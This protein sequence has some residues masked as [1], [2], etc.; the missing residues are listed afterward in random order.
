MAAKRHKRRKR[1]RF[2]VF[3]GLFLPHLAGEPCAQK[4]NGRIISVFEPFALFCGNSTAVFRLPPPHEPEHPLIP[5]FSPAPSGGEGV[6]RTD[7]GA[8]QGFKARIVSGNSHPGCG[9]PGWPAKAS[10]PSKPLNPES[11]CAFCAILR[12]GTPV[13]SL[14]FRPSP[15]SRLPCLRP[16]ARCRSPFHKETMKP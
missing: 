14:N 6:R 15:V 16:A 3:G 8:V 5:S 10:C 12:P 7:E 2:A 9:L 11:S 13:F 1:M 4:D